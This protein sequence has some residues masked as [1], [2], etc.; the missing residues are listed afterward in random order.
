[1]E[2]ES[3]KGQ[4]RHALILG[5]SLI[6]AASIASAT[7]YAVKSF[8]NA[9][10]VTGSAKQR[11]VSDSVKWVGSFTRSV[12]V[13]ELKSGYGQIDQDAKAVVAYLKGEGLSDAAVVVS[14]V[15]LEEPYKYNPGMAQEYTLRQT[16]EVRSED[17]QKI[18]ALAKDVRPLVDKGLIFSTQS[19]EFYYTKLPELRVELLSAAVKDAQDRAAKIAASTGKGVGNLKAASMGVVQVLPINSTDVSDYGAY[20]TSSIEKEVMV[21]VKTT[22]VLK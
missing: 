7:F 10:S 17:V 2:D 15:M 4:S 1:M 6:A 22:F 8:D 19:L 13:S 12:P 14:P 9:L 3:F 11:I 18:A 5:L 21:T 20:D 16:V